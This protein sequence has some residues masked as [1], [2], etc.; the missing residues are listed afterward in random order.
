MSILD[1]DNEDF[2]SDITDSDFE[3]ENNLLFAV[4]REEDE[5]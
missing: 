3:D 2:E 1:S 5:E 4:R